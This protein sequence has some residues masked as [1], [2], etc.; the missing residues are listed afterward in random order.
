VPGVG[1]R[2]ALPLLVLLRRWDGLTQG[3]GDAKGLVAYVGRDPQ[4]YESGTSVHRRATISRQG[5]RAL[6]AR[7][8]MA[9]LGGLR[10]TNPLRGFYDRL[11]GRGK[12]KQLALVAAARKLL[13]WA[14][15]VYRQQQPF[16]SARFAVA[17]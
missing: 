15:A 9:A 1:A 11:V 12:A 14:W 7:L 10:G 17:P 4:P 5:E 16:D 2:T 3:R 8:Y 6:R 13:T